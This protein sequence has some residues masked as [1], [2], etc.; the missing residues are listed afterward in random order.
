MATQ[1]AA[2]NTGMPGVSFGKDFG[3]GSLSSMKDITG[4]FASS[5]VGRAANIQLQ[6]IAEQL[7]NFRPVRYTS[8]A[9]TTTAGPE[10]VS[11]A[12]TETFAGFQRQATDFFGRSLTDL[13]A[14]NEG[15]IYANTLN[16]L[17]QQ[18]AP[19]FQQQLAGLESR[20]LQQGRLGLGTGAYG[21]NPE[22]A[23]LFSAEAQ[24]DLEAQLASRAEARAT[25]TDL[26][27]RTSAAYGLFQEVS[28]PDREATQTFLDS[29]L[30]NNARAAG[31]AAGGAQLMLEGQMLESE[32]R[33]KRENEERQR[34]HE[35]TT[36]YFLGT[37]GGSGGGFVGGLMGG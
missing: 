24:A 25:M 34:V 12:P 37:G 4:L 13:N 14:F 26:I 19:Q 8:L 15:D 6:Q 29:I 27:G 1:L 22:L 7:R 31:I 17:R 11:F 5:R 21:A 35:T 3:S 33:A 28:M 16:I 32:L 36:E 23:G 18:R 20:L 9:G 2:T 10:G 30:A